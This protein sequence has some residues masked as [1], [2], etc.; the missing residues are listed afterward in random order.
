[1]SYRRSA[2]AAVGGLQDF[3]PGTCAREDSDMG[4]R[5]SHSGWDVV[6]APGAIVDH[7]A[8]TYAKGKRF[9]RRYHFY[10]KRNHVVLLGKVFG[11]RS[12]YL[13]RYARAALGGMGRSVAASLAGSRIEGRRTPYKRMRSFVGGSTRAGADLAG[14]VA[15]AVAAIRTR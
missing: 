6:F 1:M 4:L 8:G 3:Y 15:G 7:H 9:D 10:M 2:M 13:R 12:P 5:L 14:L 11:L